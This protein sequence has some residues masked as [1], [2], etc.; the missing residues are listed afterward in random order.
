MVPKLVRAVSQIKVAIM[1]YSPQHFTVI[2]HD[3]E[4][5]CGFVSALP[6]EDS[7]ITP[8]GNWVIYLQFGK[9][10]FEGSSQQLLHW[11]KVT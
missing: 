1:F 11:K 8:G 4:Q 9:H 2:A 10:R 3:A 7:H 6:L 5:H